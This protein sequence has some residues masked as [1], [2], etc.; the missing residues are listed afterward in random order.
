MSNR[1]SGAELALHH[2]ARTCRFVTK[3]FPDICLMSGFPHI[4]NEND[5]VFLLHSIQYVQISPA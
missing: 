4:L 5:M 2:L 3:C 1:E